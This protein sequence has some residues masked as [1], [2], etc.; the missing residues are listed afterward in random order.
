MRESLYEPHIVT[1][2][3]RPYIFHESHSC[4][5]CLPH[6]H[7]NIEILYFHSLGT[8][9]RDRRE[10]SVNPGEIVIFN[11]NALHA[12]QIT[13]LND[14]ECLIVDLKFCEKNDINCSAVNFDCVVRDA[15]AAKLFREAAA[16][17]RDEKSAFSAAARKASI[18]ALLVRLCRKHSQPATEHE[19]RSGTVRRAIGYINSR[20]GEPMSID[21]IADAVKMSKYYFC[22]EFRRETGFTIVQYINNLRC[23]EAERLLR[24][25]DEPVQEIAR[26]CGYENLS[27]F[28]RTYRAVT[29]ATPSETRHEAK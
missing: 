7:E 15:T 24:Q 23:L 11:S 20:L 13:D 28:T 21:E 16:E 14:Y 22:R 8:V 29:G 3:S 9:I 2:P 27:Y 25:T 26:S 6:W 18:L 4:A 10:Y 5:G 19:D 12:V 1:D 17:I